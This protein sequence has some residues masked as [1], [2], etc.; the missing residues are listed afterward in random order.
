MNYELGK[1]IAEI[2]SELKSLR[3]L[4]QLTF[5][6]VQS[7][8]GASGIGIRHTTTLIV[9]NHTNVDFWIQISGDGAAGPK[10]VN[11]GHDISAQSR[12]IQFGN[13]ANYD[14]KIWRNNNGRQGAYL[15]GYGTSVRYNADGYKD[16]D[17]LIFFTIDGAKYLRAISAREAGQILLE[18]LYVD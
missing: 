9:S 8:P 3:N 7:I 17:Q 5:D 10:Q 11:N 12:E 16:D 18:V 6:N 14:V 2:K 15:G 13:K 4:I 1:D